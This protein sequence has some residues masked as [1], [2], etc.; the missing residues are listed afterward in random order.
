MQ[1]GLVGLGKMGSSLARKWCRADTH[2][3]GFDTDATRMDE[4]KSEGGFEAAYSLD[5]LLNAVT[6]PRTI[7]VMLPVGR[8]NHQVLDELRLKLSPGDTVIDGGNSHY[9]DTVTR[10]EQ[11]RLLGINMIDAG[12]SGGLQGLEN[13]FC[14]MIGGESSTTASLKRVLEALAPH[15]NQLLHCGPSGAGHFVKMVHNAIEYGMMQSISEGF[16]LL[17]AKREFDFDLSAVAENWRS[18]SGVRSF[19]LDLT[20]NVLKDNSALDGVAPIVGDSGD[21]RFAAIEAIE[22]GIPV[23]VITQALLSR[24]QTQGQGDFA[25][26]VNVLLRSG[27]G[28]HDVP[29]KPVK[30]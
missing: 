4:L 20:A 8:A 9:K 24:F 22:Q 10:A 6:A 15:P 11:F 26:K 2:V 13:G 23:P 3:V 16:S 28:G 30:E 25:A 1:I 29:R 17:A 14:V 21:G 18:S 27:S 12:V 7:W 19:L 5:A